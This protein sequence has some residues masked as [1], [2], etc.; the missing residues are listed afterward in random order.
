M[1]VSE[2]VAQTLLG[3]SLASP[4]SCKKTE[5]HRDVQSQ[6]LGTVPPRHEEAVPSLLA[7]VQGTIGPLLRER[8]QAGPLLSPVSVQH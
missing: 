3:C 5:S 8:L 7:P 4:P 6:C 1:G 2:L